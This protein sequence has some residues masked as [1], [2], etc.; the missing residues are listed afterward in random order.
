[1]KILPNI[2][3][4]HLPHIFGKCLPRERSVEYTLHT[5]C[6]IFNPKIRF[7]SFTHRHQHSITSQ[8]IV[9]TIDFM[10]FRMDKMNIHSKHINSTLQQPNGFDWLGYE[11]M[12]KS[13][14]CL[15][16]KW[17]RKITE[18]QKWRVKKKWK[19]EPEKERG[20]QE[21][22]EWALW[23]TANSYTEWWKN[24]HQMYN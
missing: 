5:A 22:T 17:A 23:S 13:E 9:C 19:Y 4:E 16:L 18:T 3:N 21:E 1:M 15:K 2:S 8:S 7:A 12:M 20:R 11:I 6:V 24:F 14:V 10:G